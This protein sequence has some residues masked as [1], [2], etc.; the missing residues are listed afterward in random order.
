MNE[1]TTTLPARRWL[2]DLGASA[3]LLLSAVL[4]FWPTFGSARLLPAVLGG[5]VLGLGI[6]ALA[7]WRRW[8]TL[9]VA[10]LVIAAYFLFGAAFALPHTAIAG[11]VPTIETFRQLGL[12]V[13]T[14]W[15]QLLTTV[16]PVAASDGHLLVPFLLT[17]VAAAL[18]GSFALRLS[19]PAWALVP[20][21][22]ALVL[23]IAMGV[24]EPAWPVVQG[25]VFGVVAIVWL[26][27]RQRWAPQNAAVSVGEVDP[28][29]AAQMR[30]RRL[31]SGATVLAVAC[32][33]GVAASSVAAPEGPRQ[34][35]RDVIIPPFDI[36][37]YASPLQSFRKYVRDHADDALFTVRG[38]PEGARV[39]IG[40][41]DEY[42]GIV[43][44][45]TDGGQGTSSAFAPLRGSMSA[46]AEGIPVTLQIE[47]DEYSAVWL[48]GAGSASEIVFEGSAPRSCAAP[49]TTTR[50][51]APRSR[52]RASRAAIATRCRR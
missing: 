42:N 1:Q 22:A 40:V 27:V 52:P 12:G 21:A 48:P 5:L 28:R 43:Y 11:V 7:A 17:L 46:E 6:A 39:R 14:S 26:A 47:V 3:L 35:F 33:L 36:R 2:L 37:E 44:N 49:R 19:R 24:P 15:K 34:I 18:T 10:G 25:L 38:L 8:G 4:G 9:S 32:G 45:V 30:L 50:R 16:A 29:R 13:V 51:P 20:A 23:V 41:M 31:I